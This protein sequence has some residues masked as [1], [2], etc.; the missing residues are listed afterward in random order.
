MGWK[1]SNYTPQQ[2]SIAKPPS[3]HFHY[4]CLKAPSHP[5]PSLHGTIRRYQI[6]IRKLGS[7]GNTS[8]RELKD[9][10]HD[11]GFEVS[12]RTVQRDI[13][14]IR[15]DFKVNITYKRAEN[16]YF[17]PPDSEWHTEQFMRLA[18]LSQL[19]QM[20]AQPVKNDRNAIHHISFEN[21]G[22]QKGHEHMLPL[23]QAIQNQTRVII[24]HARFFQ[25]AKTYHVLPFMLKEFEKR[26]YLVGWALERNDFRSFGLDRINS[27]EDTGESFKRDEY[28]NPADFYA[29][30]IGLTYSLSPVEYVELSF[31]PRQGNYVKTLPLH[32]SQIVLVDNDEE[33]RVRLRVRVNFELIQKILSYGQRV[34]VLQPV[35]LKTKVTDILRE[36]LNQYR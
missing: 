6:I 30:T 3:P 23:L 19:M 18:N 32:N 10:L 12:K 13:E 33:L 35:H 8:L 7:P 22:E 4:H 29:D 9:L 21:H 15:D 36:N 2:A 5:M 11:M 26:W 1:A 31:E 28:P 27:V 20:V 34:K 14:H 24:S 17:I 25:E 16:G